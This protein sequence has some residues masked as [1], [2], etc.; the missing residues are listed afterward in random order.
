MLFRL[1]RVLGEGLVRKKNQA[2]RSHIRHKN[3]NSIDTLPA[4]VDVDSDKKGEQSHREE[5]KEDREG[6]TVG[7]LLITRI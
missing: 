3:Y 4:S 2:R 1:Y 5:R 6:V 7:I